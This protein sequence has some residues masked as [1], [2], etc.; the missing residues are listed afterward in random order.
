VYSLFQCPSNNCFRFSNFKIL[1]LKYLK[2]FCLSSF[3]RTKQSVKFFLFPCSKHIVNP[4][5]SFYSIFFFWKKTKPTC[6]LLH[7]P[8][9][10]PCSSVSRLRV[11]DCKRELLKPLEWLFGFFRLPRRL[12]RKTRH[13]RRTAGA[14]HGMCE[15]ALTLWMC[16]YGLWN[17][18]WRQ[19]IPPIRLLLCNELSGNISDGKKVIPLQAWRGP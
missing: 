1:I 16:S 19:C 15:L 7:A 18:T 13:W 11:S 8:H 3:R 14:R 17:E 6:K 12:S 4:V 10:C 5:F 2:K 9:N